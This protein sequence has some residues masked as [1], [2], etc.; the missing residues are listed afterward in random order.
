MFSPF[1]FNDEFYQDI[2]LKKYSSHY[3]TTNGMSLNAFAS[4]NNYKCAPMLLVRIPETFL[5]LRGHCGIIR[6]ASK[7]KSENVLG[8]QWSHDYCFELMYR[9]A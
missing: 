5:I 6:V 1:L 3:G 2:F 7:K 9:F 4:N 8:L